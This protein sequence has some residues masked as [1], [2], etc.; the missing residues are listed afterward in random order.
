M[1]GSQTIATPLPRPAPILAEAGQAFGVAS[2]LPDQCS[3]TSPLIPPL[4]PDHYR[5]IA[6]KLAAQAP[7]DELTYLRSMF[8]NDVNRYAHFAGKPFDIET[9]Q[10]LALKNLE[11]YMLV[12]HGKVRTDISG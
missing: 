2:F 12:R 3:R 1:N 10:W 11:Q 5:R 9:C 6:G 7:A 4:P 8:A